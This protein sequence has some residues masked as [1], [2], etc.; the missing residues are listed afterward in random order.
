MRWDVCS[1]VTDDSRYLEVFVL[2]SWGD[3]IREQERLTAALA[4]DGRTEISQA[5]AVVF[6][7]GGVITWLLEEVREGEWRV[8]TGHTSTPKRR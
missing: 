6:E 7:Y 8:L 4:G 5:G 3:H 1:D 2:A